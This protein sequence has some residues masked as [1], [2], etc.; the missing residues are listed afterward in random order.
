MKKYRAK[1]GKVP[2]YYSETNYTTAQMIHEVIKQT[3]A[4]SPARNS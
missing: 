1:F 2:S 4:I 3:T